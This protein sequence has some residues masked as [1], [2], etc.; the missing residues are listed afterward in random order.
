M[1][2]ELLSNTDDQVSVKITLSKKGSMLEIEEHLQEALNAGGCIAMRE[3][4]S[5]FDADGSPIFFGGTKFTAKA[6]HPKSYHTPHGQINVERY[7]YQSSKGGKSFCPL[8]TKANIQLNATPRFGK[9]VAAKYAELGAPKLCEDLL[10]SN[11]RK[12]NVSYA[13]SLGNFYGSLA[14]AKEDIWEYDMPKL[15][16][17]VSSVS[18]SLDGTCMPLKGGGFREAMCGSVSLYDSEGERLHT[19]YTGNTPE[20]GKGTFK[21]RFSHEIESVKKLFP[22]V[23]CIGLADG[24]RDNWTFLEKY[25]DDQLIDFYH[26][27]E[28]ACE[29]TEAIFCGRAKEKDA[30]LKKWLHN[31]KHMKGGAKRLLNEMKKHVARKRIKR[32]QEQLEKSITYFENNYKKM[33]YYKFIKANEPIGSGVIEA[34][35]KTLVKERLCAS[36]MRWKEDGAMA[37]LKLRS[38]KMTKGRWEQFWNNIDRFGASL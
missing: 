29:A 20:Y 24:A 13:Q 18:L 37:V 36:G 19:I 9:I 22:H 15:E 38:L 6:R 26:A 23:H 8:E 34:A 14:H 21:E 30:W 3:I 12:I 35:C 28:Y 1:N 4:I 16:K 5:E 31:L 10:E 27:S 33:Q 2:A 17:E 7:L 25:A 32:L 11:A